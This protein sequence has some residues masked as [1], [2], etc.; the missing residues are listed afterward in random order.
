MRLLIVVAFLGLQMGAYAADCD[1][2]PIYCQITKNKPSIKKATAFKLSNLIY[3]VSRRKKIPADI[4]TAIIMQ[5][6]RYDLG[7]TNCRTGFEHKALIKNKIKKVK[8][9][10]DFGMTQINAS[11]VLK[12]DLDVVLLRSD[13]EYSLNAGAGILREIEKR[14]SHREVKWWSRYNASNKIKRR[15]YEELVERYLP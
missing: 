13:I 7:A 12:L 4:F 14:Y 1:K 11:N 6:S 8:V 3:N 15:T 9:C 10:F 2:H 5:E